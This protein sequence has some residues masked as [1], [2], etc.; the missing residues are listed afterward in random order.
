MKYNRNE[1]FRFSFSPPLPGFF[2]IIKVHNQDYESR[3]GNMSVL[4]ISPKGVKFQSN[5]ELHDNADFELMLTLKLNG[6]L[7]ELRGKVIWKQ[8]GSSSYVYGFTLN[9]DAR[10]E[11]VIVREL[12][13]YNKGNK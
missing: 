4:D 2:S 3:I 5:L 12:K 6:H 11:E 10:L 9:E 13:A 8:R 7:I 1:A